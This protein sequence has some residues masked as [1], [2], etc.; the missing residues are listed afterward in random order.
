MDNAAVASL[1]DVVSVHGLYHEPVICRPYV[2]RKFS[3]QVLIPGKLV[4]QVCEP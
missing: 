1:E 4:G 3:A 2:L